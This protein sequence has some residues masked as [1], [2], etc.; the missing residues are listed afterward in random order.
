[1][2]VL[3][4]GCQHAALNVPRIKGREWRIWKLI[5]RYVRIG[6]ERRIWKLI[7]RYVSCLVGPSPRLAEAD[8][9]ELDGIP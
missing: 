6:R 5:L 9:L 7:F 8:W 3:K 2:A 4:G 1:M